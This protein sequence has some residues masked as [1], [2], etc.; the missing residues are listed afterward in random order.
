M[1]GIGGCALPIRTSAISS[2]GH[3]ST[4]TAPNT[5][6]SASGGEISTPATYFGSSGAVLTW[7]TL[8]ASSSWRD[9]ASSRLPGHEYAAESFTSGVYQLDML[10]ERPLP[11]IRRRGSSVVEQWTENPCVGSSTLPLGTPTQLTKPAAIV[12][13][14][15]SLLHTSLGR[16]C[17][18]HP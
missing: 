16:E 17:P 3:R 6:P 5:Q 15:F 1:H 9:F 14:G 18:H 2:S 12:A 10:C 4:T 13:V 11:Y 7:E 8:P